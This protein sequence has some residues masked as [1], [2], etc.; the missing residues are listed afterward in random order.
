MSGESRFVAS[1]P[2]A[3]E[4]QRVIASAS[5]PIRIIGCG[6][7][8]RQDAQVGL[9][10]AQLLAQD[11]PPAA[12]V[13]TAE[14]LQFDLL[15]DLQGTDLLIVVDVARPEAGLRPGECRRI[16][17]CGCGCEPDELDRA[18]L[19]T[20]PHDPSQLAALS[21]T[22]RMGR[23]CEMLPDEVWLYLIGGSRFDDGQELDDTLRAALPRLA[24]RIRHDVTRWRRERTSQS[25]VV[26]TGS[27]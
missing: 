14:R 18:G 22:L 17:Y 20:G 1:V 11:P 5:A 16:V 15:H 9:Q 3:R 4:T 26:M 24:E 7:R 25:R 19:E 8:G 2:P 6:Q 13:T 21:Q 10:L 12:C 27:S 23:E